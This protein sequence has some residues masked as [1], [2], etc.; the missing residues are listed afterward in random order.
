MPRAVPS[1]VA[2]LA[3]VDIGV[4]KASLVDLAAMVGGDLEVS[5]DG[6]VLLFCW[7]SFEQFLV[8]T[9]PGP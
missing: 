5:K 8:R 6:E 3:G 9:K 4:A 2:T 7:S 1:D